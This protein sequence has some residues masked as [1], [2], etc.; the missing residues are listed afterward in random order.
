MVGDGRRPQPNWETPEQVRENT[1]GMIKKAAGVRGRSRTVQGTW[2]KNKDQ[3]KSS[4]TGR[5]SVKLAVRKDQFGSVH[6]QDARSQA[7]QQRG[8]QHGQNVGFRES[9]QDA[10]PQ[11]GG[12]NKQTGNRPQKSGGPTR[13]TTSKCEGTERS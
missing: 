3:L 5:M 11:R 13:R 8:R 4:A 2:S 12:K 7:Q 9:S 1:M 6:N 10:G